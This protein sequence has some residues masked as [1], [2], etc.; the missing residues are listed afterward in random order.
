M[1]RHRIHSAENA[2]AGR[3]WPL[4]CNPTS[5]ILFVLILS[6]FS[7]VAQ[8][9][10]ILFDRDIKP[11]LSASCF[12]CHGGERPKAGLN[13][14][15]RE[16]AL[17]GGENYKD[18][19]VPGNGAGSRLVQFASGE[20]P[21]M[22]MPPEGKGEPL[23]AGQIERLRQWIDEGALW[24]EVEKPVFEATFSPGVRW[25]SVD[26]DENK[27][28]ELEGIEPGLAGGIEHFS[29]LQDLDKR[30][31]LKADGRFLF[32]DG[33]ARLSLLVERREVG[34]MRFG[35]DQWRS[36]SDDTGG[37][38]RPS[39]MPA[40]SLDEGLHV[41]HGRAW[42]DLGLTLPDVPRFVLGYEYQFRDGDES[43]LQWGNVSGK[44]IYPGIK[45]LD[46]QVH[47]VKLDVAWQTEGGWEFED[48]ARLEF[49]DLR[50]HRENGLSYTTGPRPDRIERVSEDVSSVHGVNTLRVERQVYDWW[51]VSGGYLF[52]EY[53]G[54]NRL[55]LTTLDYNGLPVNGRFWNSDDVTMRR[56]SHVGS[57]STLLQ[58][59]EQI[60]TTL[61]VQTEWSRQRGSG[62]VNLDQGDPNQPQFFDLVP[63]TVDSDLD[64]L[65]VSQ[66]AGVRYSGIPWSI[67]YAEARLDQE[68]V[69]QY[70]E[71][72]DGHEEFLR[73]TDATINQ[74]D[75][76]V[77]FNSSPSKW[78]S[79]GG[80]YRDRRSGSDFDTN[81][82]I[83]VESDGYSAFIRSRETESKEW[84]ARVVLRPASWLKSTFTFTHVD[85]T[86]RTK[87]DAVPGIT[88]GG[89]L[90][91]ADYSANL[92]ST[93]LTLTPCR[94]LHFNTT[95]SYGDTK[96]V[97]ESND[98]GIV[99][100]YEG[101][102][103]T[104]IASVRFV[105]TE[106]SDVFAAFGFSK[107]DYAQDNQADGLPLGMKFRRQSFSCGFLRKISERCTVSV[108]YAFYDYEEPSTGGANDYVAHGVFSTLNYKFK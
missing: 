34:F 29:V 66:H 90:E 43:T 68:T 24:G 7:G 85:A 73:D 105:L 5:P 61:G 76:R 8:T 97:A 98:T 64:R 67:V 36:Y 83:K 95:Y 33:D 69:S 21:D 94:R 59:H 70:E 47:I 57:M 27:F 88:V 2:K 79:F 49:Y 103:H 56:S 15:D 17:R 87:T 52:S 84:E 4:G 62:P 37:F 35:Y 42:F 25:I 50:T 91:A 99:A 44:N 20:P 93:A 46:E 39:N 80:G 71:L 107:A 75:L 9:N 18:V 77:G 38:Y 22:L 106:R 13:L 53:D 11:I 102:V 86:F 74:S 40:L 89:G 23:T 45:Q 65:R 19:I 32:G 92:W 54:E 104:L 30:T 14:K 96:T 78:L 28:R 72:T 16:D 60:T 26:G 55:N 1:N 58:P 63:A 48:S 31:R 12:R 10:S 101:G 100:P 82:V 3:T 41:D 6:L 81:R 51:R 108:R